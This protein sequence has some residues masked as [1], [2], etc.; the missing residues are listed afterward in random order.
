MSVVTTGNYIKREAA[1]TALA[2]L[3]AVLVAVAAELV[4]VMS[5][6][7]ISLTGLALT[8]IRSLATAVIT[9][10]GKWAIKRANGE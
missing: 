2:V 7:E 8:A 1:H 10:G 6:A 3:L 4:G 9:L 5:F